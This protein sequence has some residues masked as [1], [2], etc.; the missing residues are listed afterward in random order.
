M[1]RSS[2]LKLRLTLIDEG[3][4]V[5]ELAPRVK[6]VYTQSNLPLRPKTCLKTYAYTAYER[7][8]FPDQ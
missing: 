3:K 5:E 4:L 1:L 7:S 8:Y 2:C 6:A